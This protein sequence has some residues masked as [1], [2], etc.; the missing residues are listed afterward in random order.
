MSKGSQKQNINEWLA[1]IHIFSQFS[2]LFRSDKIL[3]LAVS[4]LN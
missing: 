3:P 2:M 4:N 1:K